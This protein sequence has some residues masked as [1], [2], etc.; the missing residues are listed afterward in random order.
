MIKSWTYRSEATRSLAYILVLLRDC[1]TLGSRSRARNIH[2]FSM[3]LIEV[4]VRVPSWYLFSLI[5]KLVLCRLGDFL[6]LFDFLSKITQYFNR[7]HLNVISFSWLVLTTWNDIFFVTW[8]IVLDIT[9]SSSTFKLRH[10]S[11]L[12]VTLLFELTVLS[13]TFGQAGSFFES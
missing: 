9:S 5:F 13:R 7:P 8:H 10:V 3:L 11:K 12:L 6:F 2:V 4:K 1:R